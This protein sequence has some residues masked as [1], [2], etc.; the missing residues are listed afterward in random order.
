MRRSV[1]WP[2]FWR[3]E[4]AL[5]PL[6]GAATKAPETQR[7]YKTLIMADRA[8]Q[9]HLLPQ[10][11]YV[12]QRV[13]VLLEE[14]SFFWVPRLCFTRL[15]SVEPS[16]NPWPYS[17]GNAVGEQIFSTP[18]VMAR[19]RSSGVSS[20]GSRLMA[21]PRRSSSPAIISWWSSTISW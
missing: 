17:S 20:S 15:G 2:P 18:I 16:A 21:N 14:Q 12:T 13:D 6:P 5:A 11:R 8:I 10:D 3:G 1:G 9:H 19:K 7:G 4:V